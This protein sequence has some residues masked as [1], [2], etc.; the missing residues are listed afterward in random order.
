M[1]TGSTCTVNPSSGWTLVSE[2]VDLGSGL[3]VNMSGSPTGIC[4][5][6]RFFGNIA[7]I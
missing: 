4:G 5:S 1:M 2:S 6:Q 7:S 3:T